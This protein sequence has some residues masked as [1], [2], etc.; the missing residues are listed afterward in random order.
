[1]KK[2]ALQL[3]LA[4]GLVILAGG[5]N[6]FADNI[7]FTLIPPTGGVSGRPG[8]TVGWGYTITNGTVNWLVTLSLSADVFQDGT[9]DS[10]FDFP[11]VAPSSSA[12]VD[13]VAGVSGLFQLTWDT[14]APIG[15]VNSGTFNLLSDYYNGNPLA[16]G[17]DIGP[18][19]DLTVAYSASVTG[20]LVPEPPVGLLLSSGVLLLSGLKKL[21]R[22]RNSSDQST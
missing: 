6:A 2:S 1:M 22:E 13:F 14:T 7:S 10:F 21:T 19:P 15:F 11:A 8:S 4:T 12:T 17:V 9:P 16:G 20:S 5:G 3:A 18:A